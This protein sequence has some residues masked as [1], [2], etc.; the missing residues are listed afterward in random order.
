[1]RPQLV[2]N[3]PDL[4]LLETYHLQDNVDCFSQSTYFPFEPLHALVQA[5]VAHCI[6]PG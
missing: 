1:M 4:S 5:M 6:T 3:L 2:L